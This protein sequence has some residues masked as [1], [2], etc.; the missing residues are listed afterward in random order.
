VD[1]RQKKLKSLEVAPH[2]GAWIEMSLLGVI[3]K[4]LFVAPHVGAWIEISHALPVDRYNL[5]RT[6][7][8][9]VD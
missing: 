3:L 5:G 9:C 2:V 6:S 4:T 8:R 7:R 1:A